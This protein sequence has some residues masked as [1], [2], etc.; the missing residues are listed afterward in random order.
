MG[1]FKPKDNLY[2]ERLLPKHYKRMGDIISFYV[3]ID[4][5]MSILRQLQHHHL[6]CMSMG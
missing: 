4:L 3:I 5:P 2:F 1:H 6:V